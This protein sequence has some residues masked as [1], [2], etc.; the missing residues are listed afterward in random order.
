MEIQEMLAIYAQLQYPV[1]LTS[2]FEPS[3]LQPVHEVLQGHSTVLAG[4]SGVGKSSLLSAIDPSIQLKTN[5]VNPKSQK[6]RHTTTSVSIFPI[7][8]G[9]FV[10]DTPGI[11][12]FTLW[13]MY[14]WELSRYFPEIAQYASQCKYK[15]CTH[16]H[17]PDCAVKIALEEC[18]I[19]DFRYQSYCRILDSILHPDDVAFAEDDDEDAG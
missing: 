8:G 3:T 7:V 6:G 19:A 4:H 12:E 13:Q 10:V 5:D 16:T 11:R 2:I 15:K 14:P 17:E 1:F 18:H 9:G